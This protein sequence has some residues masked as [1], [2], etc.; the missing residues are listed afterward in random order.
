MATGELADK[1][2]I[3]VTTIPSPMNLLLSEKL[4]VKMEKGLYQI[5]LDNYKKIIDFI[6]K[7]RNK[8]V[9]AED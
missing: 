7:I 8:T 2:K 6:K 5:N 3:P 4:V 1:L 9:H